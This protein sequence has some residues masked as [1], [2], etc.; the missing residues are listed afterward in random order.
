MRFAVLFILTFFI[1]NSVALVGI[2]PWPIKVERS[3]LCCNRQRQDFQIVENFNE[4][5]VNQLQICLNKQQELTNKNGNVSIVTFS[6]SGNGHFAISDIEEFAVYQRA[7]LGAFAETNGFV[8]RH[9]GE[10]VD[11]P[12]FEKEPD[13][14]W[15]K[16]KILLDALDT[17]A[18]DSKYIMWIGKTINSVN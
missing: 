15:L 7:L 4:T 13:A 8:F 10:K 3:G 12:A 1:E 11:F 5:E 2:Q 6:S 9:I 14:R 16:I 18:K 17:W